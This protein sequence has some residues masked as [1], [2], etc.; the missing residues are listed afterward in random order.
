[1]KRAL[2]EIIT[3]GKANNRQEISYYIESTFFYQCSTSNFDQEKLI[4]KCLDWL[5]DNELIRSSDKENIDLPDGI[6]YEATPLGLA[7]IS[8]AIHPDDGI[9]LVI[10]L[11]KAQRNICVE[12]DLHLIYLVSHCFVRK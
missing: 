10:E 3:S 1:M 6:R 4:T 7:V 2:L 9:K 5:C 11:S 12:N 8:S